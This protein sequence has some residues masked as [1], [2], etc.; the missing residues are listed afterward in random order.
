MKILSIDTTTKILTLAAYRDGIE[1]EYN[2]EV[3]RLL[4]G[5]LDKTV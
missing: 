3:G 4:S 2:L 1:A 5:I